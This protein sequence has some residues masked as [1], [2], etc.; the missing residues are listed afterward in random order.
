[1]TKSRLHLGSFAVVLFCLMQP[2][3][4]AALG[5]STEPSSQSYLVFSP[6]CPVG[7]FQQF[8]RQ[9]AVEYFPDRSGAA[10][11]NPQSL[12][13]RIAFNGPNWPNNT[14]TIAF[15]RGAGDVWKATVPLTQ[16][17]DYAIWYVRDDLT[18]QRDDNHGQY[19]DVVF[20]DPAGKPLNFGIADRAQGYSGSIFSDDI[21]RKADYNRAISVIEKSGQG[22]SGLLLYDEWVYKF[23]RQNGGQYT[24]QELMHELDAGLK[25]HATDPQYLNET[26]EFLIN[27]QRAF[28]SSLIDH[29]IAAADRTPVPGMPSMRSEF[30]KAH[31]ESIEDP[32]KRVKALE[33]WLAHYSTPFYENEVRKEC[34]DLYGD[35]GDV[36]AAERS[37]RDL[38]KRV[39]DEA[40]LY[41]TMASIY[42]EHRVKL[43]RA[44]ALLDIAERK[45]TVAGAASS[46]YIVILSPNSPK[47]KQLLDFWRGK[48]YSEERQWERAES[49][50][51][52]AVPALN[53]AKAYALL[54]YVEEQEHKWLAA[55]RDYLEAAVRSSTKHS[56][57]VADFVRLSLK[58]G[59]PNQEAAMQE[60]AGANH[61]NAGHYRVALVDLPLPDFEFSDD[62]GK[63][64][65]SSSL[66]GQTTVLDLWSTWCAGCVSELAGFVEFQR[67]HPNVRLLLLAMNSTKPDI[68]KLFRSQDLPEGDVNLMN[69]YDSAK[70]GPNGVPQTYV[71]DE[72]GHIRIVHYGS[73]PN[74]VAYLEADLNAIQHSTETNAMTRTR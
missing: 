64:I 74:V 15:Q 1:M 40:D 70:F 18:K 59:T 28:P 31:A 44:L 26:A 73:L 43:D 7:Q 53:D 33:Y 52:T 21:K 17:W 9:M 12:T 23:L 25:A 46:R 36:P 38:Q 45:L 69:A 60:F 22:F 39:P 41:A 47:N 54:G 14:R 5:N 34:L 11:K 58:T 57:Y 62:V 37:F 27:Y 30:E 61:R 71:I 68:E 49:F 3:S 29:A 50:L 51:R 42:I 8:T 6:P 48:A 35:I 4:L 66:R 10:I 13:L 72:S 32:A 20:C 65:Q 55:K 56:E 2:M 63:K 67:A 19:W 16:M 24:H